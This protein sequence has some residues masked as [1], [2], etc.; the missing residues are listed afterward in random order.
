MMRR[1]LWSWSLGN[2]EIKKRATIKSGYNISKGGHLASAKPIT[3]CGN[4]SHHRPLLLK[5]LGFTGSFNLRLAV[6]KSPEQAAGLL[7]RADYEN[8]EIKTDKGI[9]PNLRAACHALNLKYT[10]VWRRIRK[11]GWTQNRRQIWSRLRSH[12]K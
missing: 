6:G 10:T 8:I 7:P 1:T 11:G 9:W 5:H 4:Y 3:V 12:I 2:R